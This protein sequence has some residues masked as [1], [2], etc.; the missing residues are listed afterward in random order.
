MKSSSSNCTTDY[1]ARLVLLLAAF[2]LV[3]AL[4]EFQAFAQSSVDSDGEGLTDEWEG[5]L[6]RS[7]FPPLWQGDGERC[8]PLMYVVSFIGTLR[9]IC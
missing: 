9:A 3:V 6:A 1:C 5:E 4:S 7:Y 8:G 2:A